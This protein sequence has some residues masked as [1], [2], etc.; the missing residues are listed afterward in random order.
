M[1]F[2]VPSFFAGI[3]TVLALLVVGF[4]GGVLMSGVMMDKG[5]REPSKMERRAAENATPPPVIAASPV[6]VPAAQPAAPE[7]KPAEPLPAPQPKMT[8]EPA[9][10]PQAAPPTPAVPPTVTVENAAPKP[11]LGPQQPVSLQN[12]AQEPSR[13]QA[14]RNEAK[15]IAAERRKAER[16]ERRKL[17]EQRRDQQRLREVEQ[18]AAAE[19]TRRVEVDDEDD[20]PVQRPFLLRR[21]RDDFVPPPRFRLFGD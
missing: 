9:V 6:P 4:G 14:D 11:L 10:P 13:A 2:N 1:T 17:A 12:P 21:E 20:E 7:P 5:P 16:A 8:A 19:Q 3:G 15:R 18:K